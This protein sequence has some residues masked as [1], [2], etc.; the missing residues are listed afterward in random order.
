MTDPG[1]TQVVIGPNASM[2][3]RMA[4]V[5]M[6]SMASV[7]LSIAGLFALQ[8]YWPVLPFAGLELAALA[9]ALWVSLKRN[10]YREVIVFRDE[11]MGV[12]CGLIGEGA[13]LSVEW[14]RSSTRV[15]VECGPHRNDPTRLVLDN[16]GRQL[17]L[18][19]CLTDED[20]DRLATRLRELI[21]P[22]W[23]GAKLPDRD[24][25]SADFNI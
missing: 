3:A 22:G 25:G 24:T 8:G 5:F 11:L 23:R 4:A 14:P 21:H 10:A 18:A 19:K 7:S 15:L 13:T 2:S 6:A 16:L 20:R 17:I 1:N 12:R 9:A